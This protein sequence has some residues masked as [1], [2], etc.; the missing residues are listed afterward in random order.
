[1]LCNQCQSEMKFIKAGVSQRTGRPYNAFWSCPNRCNQNLPQNI[2]Q[3]PKNEIVYSRPQNASTGIVRANSGLP[4]PD[5]D[6]ISWGKCKYGFLIETFKMGRT[7]EEKTEL[8]AE[9]WADASMRKLNNQPLNPNPSQSIINKN[10]P[11]YGYVEP[12]E[13]EPYEIIK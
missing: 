7:L 12:Y 6:S 9:K 8:L 1:M 13:P 5:W 11:Q 2:S 4:R 10:D 3:P